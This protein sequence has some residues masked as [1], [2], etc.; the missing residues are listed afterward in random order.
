MSRRAL[1]QSP[2]WRSLWEAVEGLHANG[3]HVLHPKLEV[4]RSIVQ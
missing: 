3:R 4:L 1:V 2:A